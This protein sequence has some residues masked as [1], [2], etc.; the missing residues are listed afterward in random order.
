MFIKGFLLQS[1]Q[2]TLRMK[3]LLFSLSIAIL[4]ASS[5]FAADRP[6]I[7]F[8]L[9]DD[10]SQSSLACYGNTVIQTPNIDALADRGVRF[11]N[12]CVNQPICWV[13][14]TTILTGL[15]ARTYGTP[16]F[17]DTTRPDAAKVLVSDRLRTA[18]YKTGFF[19]KW[20]AKM[21]EDFHPEDHFDNFEAITRNPYYKLQEDGSVRHETDIVIDR[22]VTFLE[23]QSKDQPFFLNLWFNACHAEDTDRRP[24]IGFYPWPLDLTNMY[25]DVE[26]ERPRIDDPK[27]V[28]TLP[29]FYQTS[30]SRERYF[31]ALNTP[32]KY[33]LNARARARMTTGIDQGIGRFLEVLDRLGFSEN[34][35]VVY[36]ADN[37]YHFGNRGLSGKWSHYE[38][39]LRVPLIISDPRVGEEVRG[40]TTSD[41]VLNIDLP[42]TFL[43]WAGAEIPSEFQGS[44]LRKLVEHPVSEFKPGYWRTDTFHEHFAVRDRIPAWEGIRDERYTYARYFDHDYEFLHDRSKDPDEIVNYAA[45]PDYAEDLA[46]LRKRT[47]EYI[48]EYGSKLPPLKREFQKSTDA[49]PVAAAN[50]SQKPDDEGFISLFNGQNLNNWSYDPQYWSVK[51]GTIVGVADGSLKRTHFLSWKGGTVQNFELRAKVRISAGGNSGLQYRS[52]MRPEIGLDAM[53]GYQCDIVANVPEYNGMLYEERGR[54]ILSHTGEKV[55]IDPSGQSWVVGKMEVKTFTPGEWHDYRVLVEGNHH[56][57]WIDGHPTT[58]LIDL[59]EKGRSLEGDI[60]IQVHPGPAMTVEFKGIR[61]KNLPDDLPLLQEKEHPIPD[62]A[63]GVK[64]QAKLPPDWTPPIYGKRKTS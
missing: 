38:E 10:Q 34:T 6:N 48:A 23:Q 26:M 64:P 56:R 63:Y 17:P 33:Q 55:I 40:R 30:L 35:I 25:E 14:R 46:R 2:L 16:E 50:V 62:D 31:W 29:P 59:D 7:V 4:A 60:G 24:G 57:H 43:D 19:G 49:H 18:G 61:L 37:G 52:A 44:S 22:G 32:L 5:L 42:S 3:I 21:P 54:R 13:S 8:F 45:D 58:D 39:A 15:T 20:N 12:A 51:D 36:S 27:S 28:D 11:D 1:L 53:S 9:T 47:D 41:P